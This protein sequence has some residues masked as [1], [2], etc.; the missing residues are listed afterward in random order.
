MLMSRPCL[1]A[2]NAIPSPPAL[3]D[4]QRAHSRDLTRAPLMPLLSFFVLGGAAHSHDLAIP[5][6]SCTLRQATLPTPS[7][8]RPRTTSCVRRSCS[9]PSTTPML[10]TS[11]ASLWTIPTAPTSAPAVRN[12]ACPCLRLPYR[13][14]FLRVA[15][16]GVPG[17]NRSALHANSL[18]YAVKLRR[19]ARFPLPH[20][21]PHAHS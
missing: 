19:S 10:S 2:I 17:S 21:N 14:V 6:P 5:F 20:N 8:R 12:A 7:S 11:L 13:K 15:P 9:R 16:I 18:P 4:G 3:C 1:C